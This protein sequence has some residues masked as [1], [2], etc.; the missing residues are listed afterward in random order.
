M[1]GRYAVPDRI[2]L[3]IVNPDDEIALEDN[4]TIEYSLQ[5]LPEF[6]NNTEFGTVIGNKLTFQTTNLII[7][8][9]DSEISRGRGGGIP[10]IPPE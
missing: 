2:F 7:I 4:M 3:P 9:N 5:P 1:A 8:D 10:Y 6:Q